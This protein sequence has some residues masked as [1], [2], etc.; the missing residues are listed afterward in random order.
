VEDIG[1]LGVISSGNS[2]TSAA[3]RRI[4]CRL[5][6]TLA[7]QDGS[8]VNPRACA[9]ATTKESMASRFGGGGASERSYASCAI[10]AG[11]KKLSAKWQAT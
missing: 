5:N 11:F 8:S 10:L 7:I 6:F 1:R 9:L 3:W 2:S 4:S